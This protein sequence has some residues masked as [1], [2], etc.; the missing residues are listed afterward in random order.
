M[1]FKK[2]EID[3]KSLLIGFLLATVLFLSLGAGYSGTQDV[4]IVGI[5]TYDK[6]KVSIE[7][8]NTSGELPVEIADVSSSVEV[9]VKIMGTKYNTP[10]PVKIK[11]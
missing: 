2:A 4:R 7:K 11:E 3:I 1:S 9:P 10:V 6:M 8:I 5:N